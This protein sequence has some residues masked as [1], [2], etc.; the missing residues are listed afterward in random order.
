M[1]NRNSRFT[2]SNLK[3]FYGN[4][5]NHYKECTK[6]FGTGDAEIVYKELFL[7]TQYAVESP[8]G[9]L[10]HLAKWEKEKVY[11]AFHTIFY[12][13]PLF[14]RLPPDKQRSFTPPRPPYNYLTL[15]SPQYTYNCSDP[16]LF[17]WVNLNEN[18][19]PNS[20]YLKKPVTK[21]EPELNNKKSSGLWAGLAIVTLV[22]SAVVLTLA[23][24]YYLFYQ[25]L[26]SAER[27]WYKEGWMRAVLM[28]AAALTVSSLTTTL[29]LIFA[30]SPII[31][32]ALVAGLNPITMLIVTGIG[33]ASIGASLGA[34]LM[35]SVYDF[36]EN[37]AHTKAIDSSDPY[38]FRLTEEEEDVLIEKHIDPIKAKCALIAIRVEINRVLNSEEQVPSF[39]NRHFGSQ[40]Q[41]ETQA[42]LQMTRALRRGEVTDVSVSDL[43]F[44]CRF[45]Q[46]LMKQETL[47]LATNNGGL[48]PT[49]F[50]AEHLPLEPYNAAPPPVMLAM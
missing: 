9:S 33:L 50:R 18:L 19:T 15:I 31:T 1:P 13:L 2:D 30:A 49:L 3:L 29:T 37:R 36:I 26:N 17:N 22:F 38:R 7:A 11:T 44:D 28:S 24:W 6:K 42:L 10:N 4:L 41:R 34:F 45:Y 23:A 20:P 35:N 8:Q 27:L 46:Q 16:K 48:Y 5:L 12:A 40:K 39:L 43:K 25:F 47:A 32:V 21:N 14:N